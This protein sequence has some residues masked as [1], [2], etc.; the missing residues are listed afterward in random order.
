MTQGASNYQDDMPDKARRYAEA[1]ATD[2]EI[3]D[4]FDVSERTL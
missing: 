3:A 2:R 4:L 1:G